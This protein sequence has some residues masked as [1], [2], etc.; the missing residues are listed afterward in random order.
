MELKKCE[1]SLK[2]NHTIIKTFKDVEYD[3]LNE[4]LLMLHQQP[5]QAINR[6]FCTNMRLFA[7]VINNLFFRF[8]RRCRL[9]IRLYAE[10]KSEKNAQWRQQWWEQS[11]DVKS[12]IHLTYTSAPTLPMTIRSVSQYR[13][14]PF[15]PLRLSCKNNV[16]STN[17]SSNCMNTIQKQFTKTVINR[18]LL[19]LQILKIAFPFR[20]D[21][22]Q[23]T[24]L[25]IHFYCEWI[26]HT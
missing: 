21:T 14:A 17:C 19:T 13:W 4:L 8:D 3:N 25:C 5:K 22:Q 1:P 2:E 11:A 7:A 26:Q 10:V 24:R 20:E 15:T 23:Q 12:H 18:T 6:F 9:S 16:F